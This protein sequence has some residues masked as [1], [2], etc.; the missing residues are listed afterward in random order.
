MD[1][2]RI[3]KINFLVFMILSSSAWVAGQNHEKPNLKQVYTEQMHFLDKPRS[4]VVIGGIGS[5]GAEI[6]KDGIFY[7]WSIVNNEPKG[8][9]DFIFGTNPHYKDGPNSEYLY[10]PGNTLFFI[11]RYQV[12]GK[13]PKMKLLQID[14]GYQ[15]AGI[16]NHIY[17]FPWMTGIDKIEYKARF[18][19]AWLTFTDPDMPFIVEMEVM[20]PFIPND[21]KNSSLPVMHFNFKIT[22]IASDMVDVSLA[23][24]MQNL[25]GYDKEDKTYTSEVFKINGWQSYQAG[26]A[27]FDSSH[28][29]YGTI[30]MASQDSST[31]YYLGYETRHPFLENFLRNPLFASTDRTDADRNYLK[32]KEGKPKGSYMCLNVL[33]VHKQ[34]KPKEEFSNKFILAWHFPN[35]YENEDKLWIG[36]YYDNYFRSSKDVVQ[37]AINKKDELYG[38]SLQFLN[39]FYS[40]SAPA[41]LLDEV[42]SQLT[43]FVTSSILTRNKDFGMIEGITPHQAWGPVGTTDVNMYGGVMVTSL[44]PELQESTMRIHKKLQH[45]GG[46]I[47]HSFQKGMSNDVKNFF[48]VS[49]R[50]D[51]NSQYVI[52]VMRDYFWTNDKQYLQEFWPSIKMAINYLVTKRDLDG[53]QQPDMTGIMSS[54]DNFAMYGVASYIQS[55]WLCALASAIEGAKVM[56]DTKTCNLYTEIYKK[57]LK[58]GDEKLWN[59]SYFRL[60]NSSL[61]RMTVLDGT[62]HPV[63]RD[64]SGVDEGCLT[65]QMIGQ[66]AAEWSGLGYIFPKEHVQSALK[67]ILKYSYTPEQGLKN[68]SWPQDTFLHPVPSDVWVDQ[69]NTCWTGVELSFASFL[70]YEDMYKEGLEVVKNVSDRYRKNGRYFDHQEFGGHY[71]RA[72]GAWSII[73]AL[74]GMSVNQ[75]VYRFSPKITDKTYQLFVAFPGGTAFLIN[76]GKSFTFEMLSGEC[77]LKSLHIENVPYGTATLDGKNIR[78]SKEKNWQIIYFGKTTRLIAGEKVVLY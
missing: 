63:E 36:H 17:E 40:S 50:L 44:F 42:N 73:N 70:I 74:A 69:A 54:Y 8:C 39:D 12:K 15:V 38:K 6:R 4:G 7:N 72:M 46:E 33:S 53:D 21:L 3:I 49:N 27:G 32:T 64:I 16:N 31:R 1:T 18:P 26:V 52:M 55:Q 20:S 11:V 35:L 25:A 58:I 48:G 77:N 37:Y 34:L 28:Y 56:G 51:L 62:G 65:D 66:W 78:L 60:Y 14:E 61:P 19:F 67:S 13:T 47:S 5:G 9:G 75:G 41:F 24:F 43:T 29:S 71:F 23:A 57:G 76:D 10:N 45:E 59:G 68:C 22:S 2:N 30:S